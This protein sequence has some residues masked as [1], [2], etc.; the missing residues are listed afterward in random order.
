MCR[1][2][3]DTRGD[4]LASP[5][6]LRKGELLGLGEIAG[7][8]LREDADDESCL[9]PILARLRLLRAAMLPADGGPQSVRG[10]G[11][12]RAR[13]SASGWIGCTIRQFR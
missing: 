5:L 13:Q 12:A 2:V 4:A 6:A 3:L 1:E 8:I 11:S 7:A 9:D 10:A